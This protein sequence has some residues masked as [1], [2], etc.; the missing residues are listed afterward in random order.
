MFTWDIADLEPQKALRHSNYATD[1]SASDSED[2]EYDEPRFKS[3][4]VSRVLDEVLK[5][6]SDVAASCLPHL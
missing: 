1:P 4:S 6:L 5:M 2:G 3:E